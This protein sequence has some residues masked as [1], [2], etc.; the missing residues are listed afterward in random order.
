MVG[1]PLQQMLRM[2][3]RIF[4][5]PQNATH[6]RRQMPKKT[7]TP[8]RQLSIERRLGTLTCVRVLTPRVSAEPESPA[9]ETSTRIVTLIS[10]PST[11]TRKNAPRFL[12]SPMDRIKRLFI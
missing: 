2:R 1:K 12:V 6:L 9:I 5:T 10:R 3:Q 7:T 4:L 11:V 8:Y